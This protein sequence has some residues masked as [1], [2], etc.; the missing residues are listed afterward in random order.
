MCYSGCE[1]QASNSLIMSNSIY[2]LGIST[3]QY[4][5]PKDAYTEEISMECKAIGNDEYVI[6]TTYTH[7]II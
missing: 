7:F 3:C 6:S 4:C 1:S 5:V 2:Q